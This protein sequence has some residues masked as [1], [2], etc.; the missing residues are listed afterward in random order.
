MTV[1][2]KPFI[3]DRDG[4]SK[5]ELGWLDIMLLGRPE[6]LE[7]PGSFYSLTMH[8]TFFLHFP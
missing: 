7:A 2:T 5:V 6:L 3:L 4:G 8:P 1:K